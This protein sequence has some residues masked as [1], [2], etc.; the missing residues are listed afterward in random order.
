MSEPVMLFC[1][2]ITGWWR[3]FAWYPV[4]TWDM[5]WRWLCWVERR[6]LIKKAH[7]P[8]ACGNPWHQHRVLTR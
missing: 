4:R 3:W 8:G 6:A 2:P 5:R 7:L 1:D